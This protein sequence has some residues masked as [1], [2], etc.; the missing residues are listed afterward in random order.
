MQ[1]RHSVNL[2]Q[3]V[4]FYHEL[5]TKDASEHN[6]D[7]R[8]SVSSEVSVEHGIVEMLHFHSLTVL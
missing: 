3:Y 8:R 2:D 7:L 1:T 4:S 5:P 6:N